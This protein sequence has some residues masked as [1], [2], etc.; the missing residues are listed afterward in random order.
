M[1]LMLYVFHVRWTNI[2]AFKVIFI[3]KDVSTIIF[4]VTFLAALKTSTA[5][6]T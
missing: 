4:K 2:I 6:P 1:F 3:A 5:V